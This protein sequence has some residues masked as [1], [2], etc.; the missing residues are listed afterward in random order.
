MA[1]TPAGWTAT[2]SSAADPATALLLA[3]LAAGASAQELEPRAYSA[4]PV[5][6][7]FAVASYSRL[8]GAVL[9]D[10]ALPIRNI[11]AD[12]DMY[13]VGYARTFGVAGRSAS[14]GLVLPYARADVSGDVFDAPR[15]VQRT[16]MGD[17]RLRLAVN[18]FGS[19]ALSPKEF[20]Q[21]EPRPALGAS[22]SVVVPSGHYVPSR[23]INVGSNRWS[24]KP[25]LGLS[26]PFG[27]WFVEASAGAW[28]FADNSN[29]FGGQRRSQDPL[30]VTQLHG[31][32]NFRPGFWFA[33]N[34]GYYSG[35]STTVD[36]VANDDRQQNWRYGATLSFPF[37]GGWSGKFAWSKGF[38][39]RAGGDYEVI[40]FAL[41]YRWFDR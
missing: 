8:S 41:Q 11:Q 20:A 29:F 24:V 40:A 1:R 25:E 14:F 2:G 19:P 18:L 38:A 28:L 16:G 9:T 39:T 5:G 27:D 4:S 17:A 37:G 12:I 21:R 30:Y 6:T 13:L 3:V 22:L 32:Y 7:N 26:Y 10:P 33:A 23:L 15:E 36:G 31:G 35:G 34:A